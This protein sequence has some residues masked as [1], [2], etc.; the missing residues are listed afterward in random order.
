MAT[1]KVLT[2]VGA[3]EI[4]DLLDT[5]TFH[6]GIGT[7]GTTAVVG[8]TALTT[9]V[10]TRQQ[11]TD[12]QPSSVQFQAVSAQSITG[13][14]ALDEAGLFDAATTGNMYLSA[15]FDIVN[16]ESGDTFEATWQITVQ[17]SSV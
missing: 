8:D 17:D 12:T 9:E 7:G 6:G 2:T 13:T 15:T 10:E 14:R 1:V 11:S 3:G 5:K 16:L 4:V